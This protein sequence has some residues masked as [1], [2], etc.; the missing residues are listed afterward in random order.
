MVMIEKQTWRLVVG[1][2]DDFHPFQITIWDFLLPFEN[3]LIE[4][5]FEVLFIVE[6][7]AMTRSVISVGVEPT[8]RI[9]IE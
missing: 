4:E 2:S 8:E 6:E 5:H 7:R 9:S 3:L 1:N